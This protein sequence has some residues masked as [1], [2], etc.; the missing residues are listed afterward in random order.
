MVPSADRL[1]RAERGENHFEIVFGDSTYQA[2]GQFFTRRDL[3]GAERR[4]TRRVV[5]QFGHLAVALALEPQR[6]E[7]LEREIR[8]QGRGGRPRYRY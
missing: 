4:Q 2:V 1:R 3:H 5:R 6:P 8:G 7:L